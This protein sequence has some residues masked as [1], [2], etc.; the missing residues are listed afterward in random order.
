MTSA[1]NVLRG[2]IERA[3]VT[4]TRDLSEIVSESLK[5]L[6]DW[7]DSNGW[8]GYDPYDVRGQAWFTALF[9]RQNALFRKVRGAL[10]LTEKR[11][12][13]LFLRKALGIRKS[14]NPKGM[15]LLALSELESFEV[16]HDAKYLNRAEAI[17]DWLFENGTNKFGG[18]S[19]GYP[20][21]WQSRIFIP[22]GT[23]SSVVTGAIADAW[24][25]HY[26]ATGSPKSL[27]VLHGICEFMVDGLNILNMRDGHACFSY[28]PIDDFKVHNANLFA[29][30]FL[31]KYSRLTNDPQLRSLSLSAARYTVSE[32]NPDGSFYYWGSE[33]PTIIDH[34]HTGFVIRH[35]RTIAEHA[36]C[37]NLLVPID[38]AYAFYENRLFSETGLPL[39][40]PDHLFPIDI[41]SIAEA[42]ICP[43]SMTR[44]SHLP[45]HVRS[46][47]RFAIDEMQTEDGYFIA[48]LRST[49]RLLRRIDI[50]YLRWGQAWMLLALTRLNIR[51]DA[52]H[53]RPK[54]IVDS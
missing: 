31:A 19:W 40:T 18:I 3:T 50:P 52:M 21:D 25:S 36:D 20:F 48:E 27:S 51:L 13:P 54:G 26:Q 44:N 17:L 5:H 29:A 33:P 23:P 16:Q 8:E 12:P 15:G 9:G 10:A 53:S 7:F 11:L 45:N 14:I 34:Y 49:R 1:R 42:I 24:F 22:R 4:E 28:T 47:A 37:P 6:R 43:L 35:L 32:Q 46:T 2:S 41:H 39:F 30:A 38:R